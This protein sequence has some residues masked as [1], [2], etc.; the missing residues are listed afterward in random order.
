[1]YSILTA[2]LSH[3]RDK[4]TTR[5]VASVLILPAILF[6]TGCSEPDK[7]YSIG[8]T[9]YNAG[10]KT[11]QIYEMGPY[12]LTPVDSALIGSD[13][14]FSFTG[15]IDETR[16][17]TLSHGNIN[18]LI[19]IV[20][21]GEEITLN[22][23][24]NNLRKTA[25]V[26]GS[27]E[28]ELAVEFNRRLAKTHM[29]LDSISEVYRRSRGSAPPVIE[30]VRA[31]TQ[32]RFNEEAG[33]MRDFTIGFVTRNPGSLAS[34]MALYQLIDGEN[35]ILNQTGDFSYYSMVDSAL[36]ERYPRLDYVETF[37]SNVR[38]MKEQVE[39]RQARE[40]LVGP[41]TRAPEISLPGPDGDTIDL[42]SLRGNYVLL[43]FWASWCSE[44][45][46]TLPYLT[47]V[48]EKY[49]HEDFKIYQVSL[50]RHMERWVSAIDDLGLERWIHVSDLSFLGSPV[51]SV[52]RLQDIPANFLIDPDGIIIA[53]NLWG[54][55]LERSLAR[56]FE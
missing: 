42:S 45:R 26:E 40:G 32:A 1:M 8:G 44:C 39:L 19:L 12:D 33:R 55:E 10:G 30:S 41:G 5:Y 35:F 4:V 18:S 29:A 51:V 38:D 13:G 15:E 25:V 23:D 56:I 9:L 16:F 37:S 2:R 36:S 6:A 27:P 22:A 3:F 31:E 48:Y 7:G 47:R 21:P 54:E 50:D 53:G 49:N 20:S 17:M 11:I 52:Y 34:M 43:D 24:I 14:T 28:S 46:E